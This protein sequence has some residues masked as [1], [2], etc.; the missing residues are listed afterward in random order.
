MK[1]IKQLYMWFHNHM[2]EILVLIIIILIA[3]YVV[4]FSEIIISDKAETMLTAIA[5]VA[6][7]FFLYL[8]F[9]EPTREHLYTILEKQVSEI[10]TIVEKHVFQDDMVIHFDSYAKDLQR[11]KYGYFI[12]PIYNVLKRL[13][14]EKHYVEAMALLDGKPFCDITN[15]TEYDLYT[16]KQNMKYFKENFEKIFQF[17][18][19][20]M[21]L[22]TRID[23]F[24][25][26]TTLKKLLV[27]R[28]NAVLTEHFFLYEPPTDYVKMT[29]FIKEFKFIVTDIN[30]MKK[31]NNGLTKDLTSH[32]NILLKIRERY[33]DENIQF[34][35]YKLYKPKY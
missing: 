15:E 21:K 12:Y 23:N 3:L 27:A 33:A 17:Y 18:F 10:E 6:S 35:A 16:I 34:D 2:K 24:N 31:T 13:K 11:I 1:N 20:V 26:N 4:Q 32:H 14:D 5:A 22:Y 19:D 29:E 7:T 9:R 25:F 8:T 30:M 28:L